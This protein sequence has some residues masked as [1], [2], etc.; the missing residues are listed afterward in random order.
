MSNSRTI[1]LHPTWLNV[2]GDEFD[3]PYMQSLRAFLQAEK[4]AGKVIYPAGNTI[5]NAFNSTPL[6]A[7]KV[8]ILGQDPLAVPA[9]ALDALEVRSTWVDGRPV[10]EA[11]PSA[12]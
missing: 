1:Q 9:D 7:V 8:V 2:L 3:K 11:A 10:Y 4:Q 6:D 12:R 5:F